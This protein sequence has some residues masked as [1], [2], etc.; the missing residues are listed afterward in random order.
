MCPLPLR[1]VTACVHWPHDFHSF[2]P[3]HPRQLPDLYASLQN[4][5][6]ENKKSNLQKVCGTSFKEAQEALEKTLNGPA[7]ES[8]ETERDNETLPLIQTQAKK[9]EQKSPSMSDL[10]HQSLLLGYTVPLEQVY[11]SQQRLT[12]AGVPPPALS[13]PYGLKHEVPTVTPT[14]HFRKRTQS[15]TFRKLLLSSVT[16]GRL[17][18]EEKP[19]NRA[20]CT[21]PGNK[22]GSPGGRQEDTSLTENAGRSP[23]ETV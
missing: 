5:N 10:L 7:L 15:T 2:S 1:S 11:S 23:E 3:P 22:R 14:H 12:Q 19:V 6:N 8:A 20:V 4:F 18:F 21:D 9:E 17:F 16:P 13:F